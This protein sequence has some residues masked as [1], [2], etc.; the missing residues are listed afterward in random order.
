MV[1]NFKQLSLLSKLFYTDAYSE[2]SRTSKLELFA[3]IFNSFSPL[4]IF[5]KSFIADVRLGSEYTS[6]YRLVR[7]TCVFLFICRTSL[8][9]S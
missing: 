4:T 5:A 2:P 9:A 6:D 7:T 1:F 3:K 8:L